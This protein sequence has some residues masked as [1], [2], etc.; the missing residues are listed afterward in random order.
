MDALLS[1]FAELQKKINQLEY[2]EV[3][4]RVSLHEGTVRFLEL[5]ESRKIKPDGKNG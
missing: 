1:A 5:S 2:G 4:L 3:V